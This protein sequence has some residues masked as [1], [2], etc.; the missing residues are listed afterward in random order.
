MGEFFLWVFMIAMAALLLKIVYDSNKKEKWF[1]N[2]K[3]GDKIVVGIYSNYC[4]CFR[5]AEVTKISD[6][7]FIKAKITENC[8]N[9]AEAKSKNKYGDE[10]CFYHVTLFAKNNTFK[11]K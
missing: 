9:C 5:D 7:K 6:G 8:K 3:P 1:M 11:D 4:E 10:T 2:L